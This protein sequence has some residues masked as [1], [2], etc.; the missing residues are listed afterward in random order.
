M[1]LSL[2]TFA[3]PIVSQANT[4]NKP[5]L[6]FGVLPFMSPIALYKRFTPLLEYL[7]HDLKRNFTL[8]TSHSFKQHIQKT[9]LGHFDFLLTAPHFVLAAVDTGL[10]RVVA[11]Y[12]KPLSIVIVV[13]KSSLLR[14]LADLNNKTISTPP[15]RSLTSIIT[16]NLF[17]KKTPGHN[18]HFKAYTNHSAAYHAMLGSETDAA[19]ISI[20]VYFD[21]INKGRALKVLARSKD[22]PA[23]GILAATN[24]P[25][26]VI[27]Q[28]VNALVG[29]NTNNK[30]RLALKKMAFPGYRKASSHEYE[31]LP[32]YNSPPVSSK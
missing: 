10:Y 6:V 19:A 11:T 14:T 29:M 24:L 15:P 16:K 23:M 5:S 22:F 31:N 1:V 30:G 3:L 25:D 18:I 13:K 12:N 2:A 7:N 17:C 8:E 21:A 26:S 9:T 28:F 32:A 27:N 20:Y 4:R